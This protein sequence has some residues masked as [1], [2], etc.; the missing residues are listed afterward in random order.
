MDP[1]ACLNEVRDLLRVSGDRGE[2]GQ[3]LAD[4]FRWRL[5]GGF[6]PRGGDLLALELVEKLGRVCDTLSDALI[7][8]LRDNGL[9]ETR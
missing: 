2:A 4:Y 3:R 8:A 1:Q 6:E 7:D 9:Q 5:N